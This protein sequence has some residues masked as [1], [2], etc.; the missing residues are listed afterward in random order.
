MFESNF[1]L[2]FLAKFK[3]MR[4]LKQVQGCQEKKKSSGVSEK[5]RIYSLFLKKNK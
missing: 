3:L 1:H 2:L 5:L 4:T